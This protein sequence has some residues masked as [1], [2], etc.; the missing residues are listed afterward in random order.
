MAMLETI[1]TTVSGLGGAGLG[2]AGALLVQRA[3][4]RDDAATARAAADQAEQARVLETIATA[5]VA[6]RSWLTAAQYMTADL[7]SGRLEQ[8][9]RYA[10]QLE[11]SYA[12][13]CSALYRMPIRQVQRTSAVTR[14]TPNLPNPA[15]QPILTRPL[16]D[17]LADISQRFRNAFHQS[18][19]A[20]ISQADLEGLEAQARATYRNVTFYMGRRT[21]ELTQIPFNTTRLE[22]ALDQSDQAEHPQDRR[23]P[24]PRRLD[25]SDQATHPRDRRAPTLAQ[26]MMQQDL[27]ASGSSGLEDDYFPMYRR[28]ELQHRRSRNQN[29]SDPPAERQDCRH[30]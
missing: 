13:F 6:A 23:A 24:L 16:A 15:E 18:A 22:T 2:A 20:Q 1:L 17:E 27:R 11:S 4:G 10:D 26:M 8:A 5:R 21:A 12:E 28:D 29:P 9:Q 7:Q 3:K 25:E 14:P 30:E 19:Q